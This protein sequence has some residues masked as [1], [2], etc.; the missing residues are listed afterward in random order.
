M[1][2]II[3]HRALIEPRA[4]VAA[5]K[6][7]SGAANATL[8]IEGLLCSTCAANVRSRLERVDGVSGARVYL[9]RGEARVAYDPS[10]AT[11]EALVRAVESAV[12]LRPFRRALAALAGR[13]SLGRSA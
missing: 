4:S 10:A 5:V 12:V 9:E 8:R 7:T 13:A 1:F 11:P 6:E 2:R 3:P